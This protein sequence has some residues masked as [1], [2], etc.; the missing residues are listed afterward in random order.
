MRA[1]LK[2]RFGGSPAQ[3]KMR[4][5]IRKNRRGLPVMK[6]P[7][8]IN[9]FNKGFCLKGR[10]KCQSTLASFNNNF[11][12]SQLD[13]K[14][15][16]YGDHQKQNN[17]SQGIIASHLQVIQLEGK[18]MDLWVTELVQTGLNFIRT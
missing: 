16:E 11:M 8:F 14:D 1:V 10:P 6:S 17:N 5:K 13:Q 9:F 18:L 2:S 15:H 4:G 3:E 12:A 7:P